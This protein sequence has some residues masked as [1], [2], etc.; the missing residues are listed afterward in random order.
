MPYLY[1]NFTSGCH[2]FSE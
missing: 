2:E 1:C